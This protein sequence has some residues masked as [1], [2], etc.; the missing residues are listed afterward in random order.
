MQKADLAGLADSDGCQPFNFRGTVVQREF[1]KGAVTLTGIVIE[2]ADGSRDFINVAIPDGLDMAV[3]GDVYRGLQILTRKGRKV[4]GRAFACGA[5]GRVQF[6][7]S[8]R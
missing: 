3:R 1:D 8:I 5:A 6:L 2:D 7:D 4:S